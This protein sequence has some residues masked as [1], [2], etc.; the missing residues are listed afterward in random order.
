MIRGVARGALA[1]SA[2][3]AGRSM[4]CPLAPVPPGSLEGSRDPAQHSVSCGG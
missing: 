4:A 3:L 2:S 1:V